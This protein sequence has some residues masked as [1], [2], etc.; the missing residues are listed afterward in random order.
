MIDLGGRLSEG[1]SGLWLA[2]DINYLLKFIVINLPDHIT[3]DFFLCIGIED[4]PSERALYSSNKVPFEI[5]NINNKFKE[6]I[7]EGMLK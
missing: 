4:K 5:T 1:I 6:I 3:T 7:V 2:E